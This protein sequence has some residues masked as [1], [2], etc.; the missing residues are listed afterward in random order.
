MNLQD[1]LVKS[2]REYY[3]G[4]TLDSLKGAS[5]KGLKYTK[6]YFDKIAAENNIEPYKLGGKK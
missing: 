2:M 6:K 1:A 5:P 3:K 4:K